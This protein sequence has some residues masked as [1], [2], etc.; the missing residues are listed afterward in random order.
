MEDVKK[1]NNILKKFVEA[2][3]LL[4]GSTY[5]TISFMHQALQ[6]IKRDICTFTKESVDI[7]LITLVTVFDDVVEY[8]E[9]PEDEID[10]KR[11]KGRKIF[12]ETPQDCKNLEK[13][14][15]N[16]LYKAMNYYWSIPDEYG[17]MECYWIQDVKNYDLLLFV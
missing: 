13:N 14:V 15:K 16:A 17:M 2:T 1:I 10:T 6:I 7:D 8:V 12:I 3:D 4:G 11:P 9:S 5:A